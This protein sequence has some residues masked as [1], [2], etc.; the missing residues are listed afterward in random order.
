MRILLSVA[1]FAATCIVGIAQEKAKAPMAP[2]PVSASITTPAPD[3]ELVGAPVATAPTDPFLA[4]RIPPNSK[5]YIAPFKSE[6]STKPVEGFETYMAAAIRKKGVPVIMVADRSQ[7]D[8][9]IAGSADKKGAGF[10]KKWLLGDF[11]RSTSAS[12]SVTNLHTGV[13]AYADSSDRASANRGLRSSAEKLAK[14]LKRKIVD[15]EKKFARM[16]PIA[17]VK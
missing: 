14:Y 8:F 3:G 7:A 2:P 1:F 13:I 15:D 5:I 11:R 17:A 6:D 4:N 16:T 9:E 12:L 10:A